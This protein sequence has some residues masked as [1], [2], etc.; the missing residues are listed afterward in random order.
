[1]MDICDELEAKASTVHGGAYSVM[2][3]AKK[4]IENLRRYAKHCNEL[5]DAQ[6]L[7][8]AVQRKEALAAWND[9]PGQLKAHPGIKRLFRACDIPK[10]AE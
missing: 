3:A 9:L 2:M 8:F 10:V 5:I 7:V 1:M 6:K 4:D